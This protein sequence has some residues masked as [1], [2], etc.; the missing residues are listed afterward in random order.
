MDTLPPLP[1]YLLALPLL[2]C[3][4]RGLTLG[5]ESPLRMPLLRARDSRG[6][7]AEGLVD[8]ERSRSQLRAQ[9]VLLPLKHG[10]PAGLGQIGWNPEEG[11]GLTNICRQHAF[12]YLC[13]YIYLFYERNS[14]NRGGAERGRERESQAGPA[15]PAWPPRRPTGAGFYHVPS[16]LCGCSWF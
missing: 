4:P 3:S 15:L 7:R 8:Q 5:R 1:L 9:G 10:A 16:A 14:S 11:S 12:M 13:V 6:P 2:C